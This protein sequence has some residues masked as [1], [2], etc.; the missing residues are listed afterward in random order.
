MMWKHFEEPGGPKP[1]PRIRF[2]PTK[3]PGVDLCDYN[4]SDDDHDKIHDDDNEDHGGN[5]DD[6]I[7]MIID[8]IAIMIIMIITI[9]FNV[10]IIMII[11]KNLLPVRQAASFAALC[12]ACSG[13]KPET[14]GLPSFIWSSSFFQEECDDQCNENWKGA[15]VTNK[16]HLKPYA[17]ASAHILFFWSNLICVLVHY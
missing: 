5:H 1:K 16:C 9:I 6:G 3:K 4:Q 11:M 7:V 14:Q 17:I 10:I 13:T 8:T 12:F 2:P 15:Q